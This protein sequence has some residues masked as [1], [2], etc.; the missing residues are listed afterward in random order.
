VEAARGRK[1]YTV[2]PFEPGMKSRTWWLN[3]Y[4]LA[5]CNAGVIRVW[6]V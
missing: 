4:W 3:G 5:A 1:P 6:I 2:C